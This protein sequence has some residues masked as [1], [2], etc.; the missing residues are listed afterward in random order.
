ML[1]HPGQPL[2][3]APLLGPSGHSNKKPDGQGSMASST[4]PLAVIQRQLE[5]YNKRDVEEFMTLFADDC[6][7][8]DL[9]TGTELARGK[10][11]IRE[12]YTKRFSAPG[13]KCILHARMAIGRV[14]VDKELITGL[15]DGKEAN[16][17]AVY[18]VNDQGLI[19]RVRSACARS[20]HVTE[21]CGSTADG[22]PL[23]ASCVRRNH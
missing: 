5:I 22:A 17:M 15:P 21:A 20:G 10:D 23:Q 11:S 16:C 1:G 8:L 6:A 4:D 13:L 18:Q 2:A 19:C 12:R 9:Q 3:A 7:L 14:V